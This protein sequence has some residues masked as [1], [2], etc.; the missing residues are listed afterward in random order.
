MAERRV[1]EQF[2]LIVLLMAEVESL[3]SRLAVQ[4]N[5]IKSSRIAQL[6]PYRK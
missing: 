4:E 5:E 6:S 2:L 3:R 1:E